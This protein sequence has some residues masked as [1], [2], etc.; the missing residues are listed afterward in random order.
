MRGA[1]ALADKVDIG[2]AAL[3][4]SQKDKEMITPI[5]H[6]IGCPEPNICI[7]VYKARRS[8]LAKVKL[9]GYF[10]F[11]TLRWYDCFVTNNDYI[12]LEVDDTN[13]EVILDENAEDPHTLTPEEQA[14]EEPDGEWY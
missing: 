14:S 10:D 12:L 13:V 3:P 4:L 6:Q 7:H 11:G 2:Y 8:K 5:V 9:W 1:K